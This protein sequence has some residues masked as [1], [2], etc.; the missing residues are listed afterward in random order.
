MFLPNLLPLFNV[1]S[2]LDNSLPPSK[3]Q[4][5]THNTGRS[6][7]DFRSAEDI[8]RGPLFKNLMYTPGA[9][10]NQPPL[11]EGRRIGDFYRQI[12]GNWND[13]ALSSEKRADLAANAERVLQFIDQSGEGA[14]ANN[15]NIEGITN[16]RPRMLYDFLGIETLSLAGSEARTLLNFSQYGY[17]ALQAPGQHHETYPQAGKTIE[18]RIRGSDSMEDNSGKET[19]AKSSSQRFGKQLRR[20]SQAHLPR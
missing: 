7:G 1:A 14:T 5:P 17:S 9:P 20:L 3:L 10:M 19:V 2:F 13:P 18:P 15:N 8:T 4:P 6:P 12:G 16:V 11:L